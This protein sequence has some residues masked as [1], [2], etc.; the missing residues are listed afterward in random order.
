MSG[1]SGSDGFLWYDQCEKIVVERPRVR[2][3]D[4]Y[5]CTEEK[6]LIVSGEFYVRRPSCSK[7]SAGYFGDTSKTCML[8][9]KVSVKPAMFRPQLTDAVQNQCNIMTGN[10]VLLHKLLTTAEHGLPQKRQRLYI[11]GIRRDSLNPNVSLD[12][13]WP[14]PLEHPVGNSGTIIAFMVSERQRGQMLRLMK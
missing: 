11:C 12:T 9:F 10:E 3:R 2:A 7:T 6:H 5:I 8:P 13:L 1:S 14:K 4:E